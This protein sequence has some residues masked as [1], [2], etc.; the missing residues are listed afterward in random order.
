MTQLTVPGAER[1]A[2]ACLSD[3]ITTGTMPPGHTDSNDITGFGGLS[4]PGHRRSGR[5]PGHPPHGYFPDMTGRDLG[6]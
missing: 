3:L 2:A 4:V 6:G 5:R 1:L